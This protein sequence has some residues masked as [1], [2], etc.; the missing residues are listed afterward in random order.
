MNPK[1]IRRGTRY[2]FAKAF[3]KHG[4]EPLSTFYRTYRRG[5]IVDIKGNGA[6]QK[7]MPFKAYHGR[8]GRVF[9]VTKHAVGVLVNKRVR[10]LSVFSTNFKTY[11]ICRFIYPNIVS[12]Y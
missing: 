8:T 4:I 12:N 2:M 5:D 10:L 1:G 11:F 9:N 3:R 6:F 7:G